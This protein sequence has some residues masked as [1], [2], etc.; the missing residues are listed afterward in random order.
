MNNDP[1]MA[2]PTPKLSRARFGQTVARTYGARTFDELAAEHLGQPKSAS[3]D[4]TVLIIEDCR[5]LR[6]NQGRYGEEIG[7]DVGEVSVRQH[8]RG[9]GRHRIGRT[10]HLSGESF[11]RQQVGREMRTSKIFGRLGSIS[12]FCLSLRTTIRKYCVLLT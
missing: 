11:V 12:I 3:Q 6:V 7:V 1:T 8:D 5:G 9:V 4:V 2:L 10:A